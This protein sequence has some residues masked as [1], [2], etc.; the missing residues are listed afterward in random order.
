MVEQ[1]D[2]PGAQHRRSFHRHRQR[3]PVEEN[4]RQRP[5]EIRLVE[6]HH[7]HNGRPAQSLRR[8]GDPRRARGRHRGA[9]RGQARCPASR[10]VEDLTDRVTRWP[11]PDRPGPQHRRS[12]DGRRAR[13][14]L[15]KDNR[16]RSRRNPEAEGDASRRWSISSTL[17]ERSH[18]VAR[19]AGPKDGSAA[20]REGPGVACAWK[21]LH[22][23]ASTPWPATSPLRSATSP[24]WRPRSPAA[25]FQKIT[26]DVRGEIRQLEGNAQ[27]D[28]RPARPVRR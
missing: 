11:R 16:Q 20:R 3:R 18:C 1:P 10:H 28:G 27:H 23:L 19:Q 7:Q 13:R 8:R 4:N 14:P 15:Q 12:G 9:A 6:R 5:G 22:P 24:K 2:S 26:V 21:D 25:T 17:S